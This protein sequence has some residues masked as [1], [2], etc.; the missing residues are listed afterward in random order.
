M[1]E[2]LAV[3]LGLLVRFGIPIAVLTLISLAYA[4]QQ[5]RHGH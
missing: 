5:M 4:R 3:L 2:V 1:N